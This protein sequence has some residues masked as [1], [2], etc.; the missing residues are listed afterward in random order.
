MIKSFSR[1]LFQ[2]MVRSESYNHTDEVQVVAGAPKLVY[3]GRAK[4]GT[5]D[6]ANRVG[7]VNCVVALENVPPHSHLRCTTV[8]APGE[9][10]PLDGTSSLSSPGGM[11]ELTPFEFE[12]APSSSW[13]STKREMGANGT[14]EAAILP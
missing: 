6:G 4:F 14:P 5:K 2:S 8:I 13:T 3:S 12:R 11:A 10:N 1:M 9:T 7:D